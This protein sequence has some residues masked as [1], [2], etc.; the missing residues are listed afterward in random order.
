[1]TGR[2]LIIGNKDQDVRAIQQALKERTHF[3]SRLVSPKDF[4]T[5][6]LLKF[7]ADLILL[8][9]EGTL[10]NGVSPYAQLKAE[11]ISSEIPIILLI[12][13]GVLHE[14]QSNLPIGIQDFFSKPVR[15]D[16]CITRL[17][18]AFKKIHRISD[19]SIIRIGDLEIDVS[20]YEVRI[21][22][23]KID[24]TYTE[25]ELLKFFASHPG[26]VFNRDVLLNKVWGYDYFGGARTVD[27]HVRR[28]RAKIE[29][30]SDQFIET[31]RNIGYK[32]VMHEEER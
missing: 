14:P 19:R 7:K 24:L 25:Y 23:G 22:G 26:Q 29:S 6:L 9:V 32:F 28:L 21:N 27:V 12:D 30:H 31:V 16:E 5:D 8:N 2:V 20:R 11:K 10:E 18:F 15:S 3:V 1:M 13:E 4:S 17:L